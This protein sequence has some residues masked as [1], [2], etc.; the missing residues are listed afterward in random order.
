MGAGAGLVMSVDKAIV[1]PAEPIRRRLD[2]KPSGVR[3]ECF[4]QTSESCAARVPPKF[5]PHQRGWKRRKE[6]CQSPYK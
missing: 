1:G 2:S 4:T 3:T 6:D 5:D